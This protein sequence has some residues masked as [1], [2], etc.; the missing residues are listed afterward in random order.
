MGARPGGGQQPAPILNQLFRQALEVGKSVR[1]QTRI[2]TGSASV[3]AV[4]LDLA[5]DVLSDL[6]AAGCW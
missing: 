1:A 5:D 2:G 3:P 6:P 4:A